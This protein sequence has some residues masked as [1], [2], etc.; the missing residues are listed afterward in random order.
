MSSQALSQDWLNTFISS[1]SLLT[2]EDKNFV[3]D[4]IIAASG[5]N[6]L[7]MLSTKLKDFVFRDFISF[8]PPEIAFQILQYIDGKQ[9]LVCCQ[10]CKSWNE[11]INNSQKLWR[12]L[13][14]NEGAVVA[15][16][17][18]DFE[19]LSK[20]E[21]RNYT[22][23]RSQCYK[24]LY[25]HTLS[26]LKGLSTGHS[27]RI[28]ENYI[29]KGSWRITSV[30]YLFGNIVTGCDDHTVQVWSVPDGLSLIMVST[31]SVSCLTMTD[32]HLFTASFN[33][34]AE[35][36]DLATGYHCQTFCGHTSAV[37][38]IDVTPDKCYLL[39]GSV[40]KT[41]KLWHLNNDSSLLVKTF[42]LHA[43]WVFHVKFLPNFNDD[44]HFLTCDSLLVNIQL[45]TVN[46]D[47]K[48]SYHIHLF[49]TCSRFTSFYHS[50]HDP[51][52]LYICQWTEEKKSSH[53][54]C[55]KIRPK[56]N[57][58]EKDF[59][60]QIP[61]SS[62]KAYLLGAGQKFAVI[63]CSISRK[64]FHVV[65]IIRRSV[66]ATITT[67]DFCMLTRNGSSVTLCN[68]SWLDGLNFGEINEQTPVFAASVGRNTVILG[69]WT[70][71]VGSLTEKD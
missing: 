9:L 36:W 14:E 5:P 47:I 6:Q 65:D 10:V 59:H 16:K 35:S 7:F 17:T 57:V 49:E 50:K 68:T 62:L 58:A 8:L 37:I 60:F 29:E 23:D 31:H 54:S 45:V 1:Y 19:T 13:A 71:C 2:D 51:Y 69:T 41:A 27:I 26:V 21:K 48:A 22:F 32:T 18:N 61:L 24:I 38:A 66:V 64:D 70:K 12:S 25:M 34:N 56:L 39:T 67:P 52:Q 33:A 28:N 11:R 43:D 15:D 53:L 30:K 46:G 20:P 4:S 40:D 63:M 3:L 55:Y 42:N 44:L